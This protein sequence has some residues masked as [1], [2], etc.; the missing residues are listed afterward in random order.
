[1]QSV[2]QVPSRQDTERLR[3][4][5]QDDVYYRFAADVTSQ[6]MSDNTSI[7][8]RYNKEKMVF[9]VVHASW[10]AQNDNEIWEEAET[11]QQEGAAL[12]HAA[13]MHLS[14]RTNGVSPEYGITPLYDPRNLLPREQ[15]TLSEWSEEQIV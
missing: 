2:C 1:M 11:F 13:Q 10:D 15:K 12:K 14:L 3:S 5:S 8:V 6:Q 4:P 9:G 7:F